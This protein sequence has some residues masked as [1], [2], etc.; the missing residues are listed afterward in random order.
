MEATEDIDITRLK[1]LACV[2]MRGDKKGINRLS[3]A[4]D[5]WTR[6]ETIDDAK[7]QQKSWRAVHTESDFKDE[8]W[9]TYEQKCHDVWD[10]ERAASILNTESRETPDV[11]KSDGG[12]DRSKIEG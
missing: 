4:C 5:I 11:S 7:K 3:A 12:S 2:R 9:K 1:E 8:D 10:E 6:K